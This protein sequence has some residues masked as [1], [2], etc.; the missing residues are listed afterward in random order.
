MKDLA[1]NIL[2]DDSSMCE[3]LNNYF[4]SVFTKEKT[5]NISE[6]KQVFHGGSSRLLSLIDI[7]PDYVF[8]QISRIIDGEEPLSLIHI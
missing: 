5:D 2:D 3:T 1:G 8:K 7:I 4:A 6:V